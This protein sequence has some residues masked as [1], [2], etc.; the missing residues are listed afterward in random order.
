MKFKI[1]YSVFLLNSS[2]T[3]GSYFIL[4]RSASK[5]NVELAISCSLLTTLL[6][7]IVYGE[8]FRRIEYIFCLH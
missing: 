7:N 1:S 3:N 8:Y 5:F 6:K 2:N 4:M